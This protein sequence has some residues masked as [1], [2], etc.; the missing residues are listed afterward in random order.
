MTVCSYGEP[1]IPYV[2]FQEVYRPHR[3]F[4]R[5]DSPPEEEESRVQSTLLEYGYN[6]STVAIPPAVGVSVSY[7]LLS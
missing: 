3:H 4:R 6:I 2:V 1:Y 7:E 5:K